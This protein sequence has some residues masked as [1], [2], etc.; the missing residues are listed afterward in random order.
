MGGAFNCGRCRKC[1]RTAIP[2]HALGVLDEVSSFQNKEQAHWEAVVLKDHLELVRE[3]HAFVARRDSGSPL[4]PML[5]AA[6]SKLRFAAAMQE[7][8]ALALHGGAPPP[9]AH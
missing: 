3:N 9:K 4:L 8:E 5:G 6:V 1:V 2:L 7:L